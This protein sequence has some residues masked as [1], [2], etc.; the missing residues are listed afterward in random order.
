MSENPKNPPAFPVAWPVPNAPEPG[1]TLR[2][3]FASAAL[4]GLLA[5]P[6]IYAEF[7]KA[8][9]LRCGAEAHSETAYRFADALLKARGE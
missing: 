5:N 8:E 9:Q 3:Y 2:D 6:A 7:L 4:T 1:M